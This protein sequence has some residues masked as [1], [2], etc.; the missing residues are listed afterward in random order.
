MGRAVSRLEHLEDAEL[1]REARGGSQEAYYEL[2]RRFE[3]PIFSLILRMVRDA[4]LAE[5]LAQEAFVKAFGALDRYDPAHKLSS[6]IFKIAHNATIDHLRKRRVDTV[7]FNVSAEQGEA[8]WGANLEDEGALSPERSA[9]NADL[10]RDLDTAL[11]QLRPEYREVMVLR[12]EEGLQYNEIADVMGLP[13][14]TVKTYIFRAR[15]ELAEIL[16]GQGW[17]G[18]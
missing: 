14:G 9:R 4:A 18:G 13:L 6:W 2:V 7:S 11:G 17:E 16:A 12:F 3:R 15:K 1:V 8:D 5:D 10:A